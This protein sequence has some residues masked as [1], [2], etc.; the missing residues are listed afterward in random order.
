MLLCFCDHLA[1][2]VWGNHQINY[3]IG[4][5]SIKCYCAE[6]SIMK[7]IRGFTNYSIYECRYMYETGIGRPKIARCKSI[8]TNKPR[9]KCPPILPTYQYWALLNKAMALRLRIDV[10]VYWTQI[11][12]SVVKAK[13]SQR[14][15]RAPSFVKKHKF[16]LDINGAT[17][18]MELRIFFGSEDFKTLITFRPFL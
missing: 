17:L 10:S 4:I 2:S 1:C 6:H 5:I 13:Q 12:D 16:S 15:G 7:P 18:V 14:C 8:S 3:R 9:C 11:T